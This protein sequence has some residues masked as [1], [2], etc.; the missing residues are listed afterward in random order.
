MEWTDIRLTVAQKDAEQA[1]AAAT[2][3]AEGGIYIRSEEHTSELQSQ[4]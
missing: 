4:N 3:I 1:E 2:M